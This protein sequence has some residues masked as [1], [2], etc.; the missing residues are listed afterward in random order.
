[1]INLD[2]D[3]VLDDDDSSEKNF[4]SNEEF[5]V[6]ISS[7]KKDEQPELPVQEEKSISLVF[8]SNEKQEKDQNKNDLFITD[9]D[10]LIEDDFD[11]LKQLS[12]QDYE[13]FERRMLKTKNPADR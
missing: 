11:W 4:V 6:K 1:M 8:G 10:K 2:L 12:N 5:Q 3:Q 13:S 9:L 7:R